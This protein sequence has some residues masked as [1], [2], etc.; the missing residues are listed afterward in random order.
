MGNQR[1]CS[2]ELAIQVVT[3]TIHTAWKLYRSAS[4][5]Q[6]DLKG[7]FNTVDH[8]LLLNILYD[9]GLQPWLVRWLGSY[10]KDHIAYLVFN[11]QTTDCIPTRAGM[12]QGSPL[13]PILFILYI[14]TLYNNLQWLNGMTVV[15]FA[16]NINIL[17]FGR[18]ILGCCR[19]LEEAWGIYSR[20]A[21]ARGMQFEASK[22][23]LIHFTRAHVPQMEAI[24]LGAINLMSTEDARFLGVWLDRKLY[25]R[26]HLGKI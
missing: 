22:S 26:A 8:S 11:G 17:A 10:L 25:Y 13:L 16:D 18:D 7:A 2:T 12:P 5:L 6:L 24:N 15:G 21:T 4:L 9:K 1:Q 14:S 23:K 3:K 19:H 20:W